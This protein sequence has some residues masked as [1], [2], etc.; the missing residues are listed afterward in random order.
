MNGTKSLQNMKKQCNHGNEWA[1]AIALAMSRQSEKVPPCW[2]TAEEVREI[3][4]LSQ[5]NVS[6]K[7]KLLKQAGLIKSKKFYVNSSRGL[8]PEIHYKLIKSK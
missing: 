6:K 1:D 3:M 5:T 8:Y 2:K 7:I 4:G